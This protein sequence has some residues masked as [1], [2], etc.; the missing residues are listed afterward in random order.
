M[1]SIKWHFHFDTSIDTFLLDQTAKKM[2]DIFSIYPHSGWIPPPQNTN[3]FARKHNVTCRPDVA[4]KPWVP[5][6]SIRV[7]LAL[8]CSVL[9]NWH[10][11][12]AEGLTWWRPQDWTWMN[13]TTM[14]QPKP[15]LY[16]KQR[17]HLTLKSVDPYRHWTSVQF[18]TLGVDL[19]LDHFLCGLTSH[20]VENNW[21]FN[22]SHWR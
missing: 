19:T 18:N 22:Q 3:H 4:C 21:V 12:F 15:R 8:C 14:S 11:I 1:S 9:N 20:N 16:T 10:N 17:V 2:F 13:A 6:H 5:G 7:K